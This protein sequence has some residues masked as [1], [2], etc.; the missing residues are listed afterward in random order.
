MIKLI[1]NERSFSLYEY[2]RSTVEVSATN[3]SHGLA[4]N[5]KSSREGK[6]H[7]AKVQSSKIRG[8]ELAR[9]LLELSVSSSRERIGQGAKRLGNSQLKI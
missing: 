1:L 4:G 6:L 9:V 2:T 8:S 7:G 3:Q 5:E